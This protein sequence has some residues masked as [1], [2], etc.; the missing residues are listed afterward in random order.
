MNNICGKF[1][2]KQ[3]SMRKVIAWTFIH[4][5]PHAAYAIWMTHTCVVPHPVHLN[6]RCIC[7]S[8]S[9]EG[10]KQAGLCNT[11]TD[12]K[13]CRTLIYYM[14]YV[15]QWWFL[16][17]QLNKWAFVKWFSWTSAKMIIGLPQSELKMVNWTSGKYDSIGLPGSESGKKSDSDSTQKPPTPQPWLQHKHNPHILRNPH[18]QQLHVWQQLCFLRNSVEKQQAIHRC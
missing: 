12:H 15:R 3:T 14:L 13:V 7:V 6:V 9:N 11:S 18:L 4:V 10:V 2:C 17:M 1:R 5:N 16:Q 8:I